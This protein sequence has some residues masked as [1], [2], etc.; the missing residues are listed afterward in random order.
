MKPRP[1]RGR[2]ERGAALA[3]FALVLPLLALIVFGTI[4]LGRVFRLNTRL[5]NAARE[6]AG[7]GQFDPYRVDTGCRGHANVVDRVKDEDAGLAT[8]PGFVVRVF[9]R[10]SV[11]GSLVP[12]GGITGCDPAA[13]TVTIVPGDRVVVQVEAVLDALTPLSGRAH[14]TVRGSH[15]VVVQG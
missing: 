2:S 15:E 14:I 5:A 11:T 13:P 12:P 4:D 6:G 8:L 3:E 9:K 1:V 10:D 7:T